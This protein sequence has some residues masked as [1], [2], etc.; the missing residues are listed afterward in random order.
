MILVRILVFMYS[1]HYFLNFSTA[2][3]IKLETK[4]SQKVVLTAE[5]FIFTSFLKCLRIQNMMLP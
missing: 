5:L 1:K 2:F 4:K 3:A